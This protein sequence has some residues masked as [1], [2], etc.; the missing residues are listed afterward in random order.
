MVLAISEAIS[1]SEKFYG[2]N[3][4]INTKQQNIEHNEAV[5]CMSRHL[6]LT[7]LSQQI[8]QLP[9]PNREM[10]NIHLGYNLMENSH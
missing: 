1:T 2:E 9:I 4:E 3:K 10:E 7:T 5:P 6:S 8:L